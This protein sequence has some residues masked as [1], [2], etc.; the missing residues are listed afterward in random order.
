MAYSLGILADKIIAAVGNLSISL[1]L[2]KTLKHIIKDSH[3]GKVIE[4]PDLRQV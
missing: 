3:S 4:A 1:G 2:S